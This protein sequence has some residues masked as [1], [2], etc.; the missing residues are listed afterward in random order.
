M[1]FG[2]AHAVYLKK[3]SISFC[4]IRSDQFL[5]LRTGSQNE[6]GG[7]KR[8]SEAVKV[9][10]QK[11]DGPKFGAGLRRAQEAWGLSRVEL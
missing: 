1:D 8:N 6:A 10:T 2:C 5:L 3:I 4:F 9:G 7:Q 11:C